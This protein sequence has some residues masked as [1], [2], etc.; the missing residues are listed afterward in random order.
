M[1]DRN[2]GPGEQALRARSRRTLTIMG[3]L[4]TEPDHKT[5]YIATGVASGVASVIAYVWHKYRF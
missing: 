4:V 2:V 5:L 1:A 3:G